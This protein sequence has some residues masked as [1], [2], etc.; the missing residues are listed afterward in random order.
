MLLVEKGIIKVDGVDMLIKKAVM[1]ILLL[2]ISSSSHATC[3]ILDN[4][5]GY[6]VRHDGI[7]TLTRSGFSNQQFEL[8]IAGEHSSVSPPETPCNQTGPY[9]VSCW[10]GGIEFNGRVVVETYSIDLEAMRVIHTRS[11]NTN[12]KYDGGNLFVGDVVGK[13]SP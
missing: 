5:S 3:F 2:I 11:T 12:G 1:G 7:Y 9:A 6:Q 13:C 4:L 8:N 10:Y